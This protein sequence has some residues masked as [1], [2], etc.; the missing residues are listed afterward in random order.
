VLH[1]LEQRH[2]VDGMAKKCAAFLPKVQQFGPCRKVVHA[3]QSV[4][5]LVTHCVT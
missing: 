2:A 1:H 5:F 3:A 4:G